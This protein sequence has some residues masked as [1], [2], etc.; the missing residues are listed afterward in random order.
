MNRYGLLF[1]DN[2]SSKAPL[3]SHCAVG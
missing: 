1:K 3:E 2:A